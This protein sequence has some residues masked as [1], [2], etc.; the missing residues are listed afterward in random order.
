MLNF[1][2]EYFTFSRGERNGITVLLII[3]ILLIFLP[4]A[5][6]FLRERK[7]IDFS[8]FKKEIEEFEKR[9]ALAQE[10]DRSQKTASFE[11]FYFDPNEIGEHDWKKL[12]VSER[13]ARNVMKY[14]EKGG[15]FW[16]KDDLLK[17]Y[18]F[19]SSIYGILEPYIVITE[20]DGQSS[21]KYA[22]NPFD[23]PVY[24][25][26]YEKK[27]Q[28]RK[29]FEY[30]KKTEYKPKEDV[31][32]ELNVADSLALVRVNGIGPTLSAR[33]IKYRNLLGG[34]VHVEQLMEVYGMDSTLFQTMKPSLIVDNARI[35]KIP[36]NAISQNDLERHPYFKRNVA[37]A[38]L[39]YRQ[40]HGNFTAI[41]DLK[42]IY[43]VDEKLFQ[44]I[45]PYIALEETGG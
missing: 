15:V 40:Q 31:L 12:G 3:I 19:D 30:D 38:I 21:E 18:G 2:K 34:F 4:Y 9:Q 27:Q 32:V 35:S 26:Q 33:I 10:R 36:I 24:R 17:I 39:N 8:Q 16:E 7:E 25:K 20:D 29:N 13:T 22:M 14:R 5:I 42:K 43:V 37:R 28:P 1:L 45:K 11:L 44:K 41:D 23:K 6:S